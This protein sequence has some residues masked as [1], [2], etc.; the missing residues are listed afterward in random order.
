MRRVRGE[1]DSVSGPFR[2]RD[3]TYETFV[4][5]KLAS[6][7]PTGIVEP[8]D[9]A[10][11]LFPFQR[12]LVSWAL[13]RGRAAIFAG[14]GLGKSRMQV[15]W[16]QK[17]NAFTG[18][19]VLVLAPLA[20]ASQ[21][22][23]EGLALGLSEDRIAVVRS[24][25]HII[26]GINVTN[27]D[28]LHRFDP[29]A[30]G[31]VVL[32]ESSCIKHHDAKTLKTLIDSFAR[33]PFKLCCTAT[34]APNDWT[35]LG[36]HAEF[37]GICTRAEMLAEF[38]CHDGGETQKWRLKGHARDAFWRWVAEWGAL[39]SHPRDLGYEQDG[40]D[41]P[42][43]HV[44]EHLLPVDDG[45]AQ[46]AGLLWAEEASSLMERRQA[47]KASIGSRVKACADVVNAEAREP[48]VV[49]CDLNAESEALA[50]AIPGAVEIR[51][52]MDVDDKERALVDFARGKVRVI[53]SKPSI[54]GFGLN[55]QHSARMAFV[56]VTDSWEA[57][58]QA[59]RRC[60]RFGQK[61]DVHVHVFASEA[62]GS[63]VA[64]LKRKEAAAG[65][66]AEALARET[67]AAV[68]EAVLGSRRHVNDYDPKE[69]MHIP[70]WLR[71]EET[72]PA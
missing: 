29:R 43:L 58:Y 55:W 25:D 46:A 39:V 23:A 28:R 62:E 8:G 14:T 35:E 21:T 38:F 68:R 34:P 54:T 48:W 50:K 69:P 7:P 11:T 57:Y 64:N 40:Y 65:E 32:D 42:P 6:T 31:A 12:D 17:V 33:T 59:V 5:R 45:V 49:W 9:L 63:V 44:H 56:G 16:A 22:V 60:W 30:F 71:S 20:V 51:G 47:R 66:M 2:R 4:A 19:P 15:Q 52:S 13:R 67:G 61:R 41:L 18:K 72:A 26:P 53:V 10:T 70:A 3:E 37:L 27:Y 36:T 24:G 1:E